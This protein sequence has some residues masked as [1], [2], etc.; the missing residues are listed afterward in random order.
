M[1]STRRGRDR[2]FGLYV[3][4]SIIGYMWIYSQRTPPY[5]LASV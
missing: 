4:Y 5:P 1:L 2:R 3:D